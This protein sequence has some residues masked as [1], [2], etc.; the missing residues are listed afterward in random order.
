ML[1]ATK[2]KGFAFPLV[3]TQCYV[4]TIQYHNSTANRSQRM[5]SRQQ[6]HRTQLYHEILDQRRTRNLRETSSENPFIFLYGFSLS[7]QLKRQ[8]SSLFYRQDLNEFDAF[9]LLLYLSLYRLV[10]WFLCFMSFVWS[11]IQ[12]KSQN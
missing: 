7:L 3:K 11:L 8:L 2:L 5:R 10:V 6:R 12:V 4:I 1:R 9:L